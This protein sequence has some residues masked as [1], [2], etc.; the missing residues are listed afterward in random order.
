M[1]AEPFR[2]AGPLPPVLEPASTGGVAAVDR[3]LARLSGHRRLMVV[4]AHP[5][6][7]DNALLAWVTLSGG[8]AAYLS[9]SRGEGG[10]NLVGPEL[11][12]PLGLLRTGELLAARRVDRA[13]QFFTRAFDFGYT[14]SFEETSRRWPR[15][16][17]LEDAVRAVRRFQPQV[18]VAIFPP[19]ERAGHGQHQMSAVIAEAVYAAAGLPD[20][21]PELT[22]SGL[23]P[24]TPS[25]LFRR[26]WRADEATHLFSLDEVDPF[27]GRSTAQIAA[28]SRSQHRSQDMGREQRIGGGRGGLVKLHPLD[29]GGSDG[30]GSFEGTETGLAALAGPLPEGALRDLLA[31]RLACIEHLARSLRGRLSAADL[32]AAVPELAVIVLALD[33]ALADLESARESSPN[34]SG[35]VGVISLVREKRA[36]AG[37]G[38]LAAAGVAVEAVVERETVVPGERTKAVLSVWNGGHRPVDLSSLGLAGS[39]GWRVRSLAVEEGAEREGGGAAVARRE[40]LGAVEPGSLL[41]VEFEAHA[42]EGAAPSRPYFVADGPIGESHSGPADLYDWSAVPEPVRGLPWGPPPLT[43]EF[44]IEVAGV[45]LDLER[46]VVFRTGDQAL[47]E[48]RRP[49]RVVPGL[50]VS[51]EPDQLVLPL[52]RDGGRRFEVRLRSNL[53]RAVS[54][55]IVLEGELAISEA[56]AARFELEPR[57]R[58]SHTLSLALPGRAEPGVRRAVV[59]ALLD[60]GER[61]A[62]EA[63]LVDY[64]HIRPVALER[65]AEITLHSLDLEMPPVGRLGFV[66]GA[67]ERLPAELEAFGLPIE[68][69]DARRLSGDLSG[70]DAIVIGSRAYETDPLLARVNGRLLDYVRA[71][72]LLVV[73]YQQYA[74]A[75]GGFAPFALTIARPHGRVTDEA[76]PVTLLDPEHPAFRRPNPI[77]PD[78]WRGWVQERGLYFADSWDAAFTPL[79]SLQDPGEGEQ[80]GALLVAPLGRGTYVY[81]GLAFFRQLPAGVPGAWR[82]FANL[83]A[84]PRGA[85]LTGSAAPTREKTDG[86]SHE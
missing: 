73:L 47:G 51:V 16:L 35:L 8:D 49:L 71:G 48:I 66:A 55:R 6:D 50:E 64:P 23:P 27:S 77:G 5:D 30:G 46:E 84:L 86:A 4:G 60:S 78:D 67:S 19:D 14:R 37:A 74:F 10:Q 12:L 76:S 85:A 1:A 39:E 82:L 58:S 59:A 56:Q 41:S 79:L 9:L 25:A 22:A 18:I 72:G 13:W 29:E 21:Y 61:F 81:T 68:R 69:L 80:R 54:G 17:L 52:S 31:E 57:G 75:Q 70:Y 2:G 24:W 63:P 65:R 38:L 36:A 32:E 28:E 15:E 3:A 42:L 62:G 11:G 83:L 45:V 53:D 7:E 44:G 33:G 20:R 34:P 26:A 43:A 40:A